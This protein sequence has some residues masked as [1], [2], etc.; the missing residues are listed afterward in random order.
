M[1]RFIL[2]LAAI[3]LCI[4]A[5]FFCVRTVGKQIEPIKN[6]VSASLSFFN[7][8][9]TAQSIRHAKKA[10]ELYEDAENKLTLF[11]GSENSDSLKKNLSILLKLSK[12]KD[13][14]LFSEKAEECLEEIKDIEESQKLSLTNIL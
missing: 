12:Q 11:I 14:A 6:S 8:G 9:D 2:A 3:V 5:A 10:V 4:S 13:K 1:K 7:A